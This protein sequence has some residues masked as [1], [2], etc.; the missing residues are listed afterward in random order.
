MLGAQEKCPPKRAETRDP[1]HADYMD[2]A[3]ALWM[4]KRAH[5][6]APLVFRRGMSKD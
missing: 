3:L 5:G 2:S 4:V 1:G 6:G